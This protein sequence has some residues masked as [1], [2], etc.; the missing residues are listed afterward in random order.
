MSSLKAIDKK[1]ATKKQVY[2][3][4]LSSP[5]VNDS[6]NWPHVNEQSFVVELLKSTILSKCIHLS[7]VN[8]K[9]WP[10]TIEVDYNKIVS[11]LSSSDSLAPSRFFLFACNKDSKYIPSIILQQIP[12]LCYLSPHE[13]TLIQLPAGSFEMIRNHGLNIQHGL[14]LLYVD[15]QLDEKFVSAIKERVQNVSQPWLDDL[16]RYRSTQLD[17]LKTTQ[18]LHWFSYTFAALCHFSWCSSTRPPW[19]LLFPFFSMLSC[20]YLSLIIKR[21]R[22]T[23]EGKWPPVQVEQVSNGKSWKHLFLFLFRFFFFF[24]CFFYFFW[25]LENYIYKKEKERKLQMIDMVVAM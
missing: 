23:S 2:K 15:D 18:P 8:M 6:H 24:F 5:Y 19:W 10:W 11:L 22:R 14:L 12:A 21:T 20:F 25:R 3:P 1:I 17:L 7:N 9:D 4:I 16:S 13:V